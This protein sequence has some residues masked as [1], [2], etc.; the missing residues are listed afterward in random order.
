MLG[1]RNEFCRANIKA[2]SFGLQE[3]AQGSEGDRGTK[4][5]DHLR[6]KDPWQSKSSPTKILI[7]ILMFPST[8]ADIHPSVYCILYISLY[9]SL[10]IVYCLLY[11]DLLYHKS[12]YKSFFKLEIN[13]PYQ[14]WQVK[15]WRVLVSIPYWF[16]VL[17]TLV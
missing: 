16:E 6:R 13:F 1:R 9:M 8:K 7:F 3:C 2:T 12:R 4:M 17:S 10:F 14:K 5:K 15:L 11:I